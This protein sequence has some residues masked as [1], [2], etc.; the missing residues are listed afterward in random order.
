MQFPIGSFCQKI[1]DDGWPQ[2]KS[3]NIGVE[4]CDKWA[5]QTPDAIALLLAD[6][7]SSITYKDLKERSNQLANLFTSIGLERGDRIGILLPQSVETALANLATFKMGAIS[8]PLFVLF[9]PDALQHR[10]V[11]AGIK[12][13]VTNCSQ[14]Q[15]LDEMGPRKR[16]PILRLLVDKSCQTCL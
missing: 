7:S 14:A 13:I 6:Q 15:K 12:V 3:Y 8:V 9:G 16:V 1:T 4:A 5:D 2:P 11:D 10:V